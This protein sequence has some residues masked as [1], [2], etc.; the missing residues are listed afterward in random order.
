MVAVAITL[1]GS[2]VPTVSSPDPY[3]NR[4]AVRSARSENLTSS[5]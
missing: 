5:R 3:W 4:W 1:L 2:G